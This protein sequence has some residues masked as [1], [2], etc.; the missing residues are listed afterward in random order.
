MSSMENRMDLIER[1]LDDLDKRLRGLEQRST[2]EHGLRPTVASAPPGWSVQAAPQ[3]TATILATQP[4]ASRPVPA[5]QRQEPTA[6]PAPVAPRPR[7]VA[8]ARSWSAADLE[9]LLTGRFLAW[10]GGL[11]ILIGAL[12]FLARAFREGWIG[13]SGRVA[14]GLG[15]G[16]VL[17]AVGAW[18][19]ERRESLFGHVLVATGLG[20]L[21]LSLVAATR[22]Y[23]LIRV[24]I[25]LLCSLVLAAAA[26]TIAVRARSQVVAAY[27]L[28][29]ALAAPYLLGASPTSG[30]V[31]FVA[32]ALVGCTAVSLWRSWTWLPGLAFLLSAPQVWSWLESNPLPSLALVALATYWSLNALAAGGEEFRHRRSILNLSS[33]TVLLSNGAFVVAAGFFVL[34]T[35]NTAIARGLWLPAIAIVHMLLGSYFLWDESGDHPF[36]LLALGTGI[37]APTMAVPV[38]LGG[39]AVPLAWAAEAAALA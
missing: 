3:R 38:A 32:T 5:A 28:V 34:D 13:P 10:G 33:A 31:A 6:A 27:G 21:A 16:L 4:P 12:F 2:T 22:L 37:A 9:R 11:A 14:I 25:G 36:G 30:T 8:P 29:T 24:D 18:F 1:R 7:V 15:A 23:D 20:T 35:G 26:A 39:H 19:F 17:F